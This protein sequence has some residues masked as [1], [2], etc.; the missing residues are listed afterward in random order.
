MRKGIGGRG[1]GEYGEPTVF[2]KT[3]GI[4]PAKHQKNLA[5]KSALMGPIDL[6]KS[7]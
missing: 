6:K 1:G 3:L 5:A 4:I 2:I 7:W